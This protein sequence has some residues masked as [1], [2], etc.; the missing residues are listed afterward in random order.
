MDKKPE[1]V[2][3]VIN[4]E[5]IE[6]CATSL[7][8]STK[9]AKKVLGYLK[10]QSREKAHTLRFFWTDIIMIN[11]I[12]NQLLQTIDTATLKRMIKPVSSLEE[13]LLEYR[14]DHKK[15]VDRLRDTIIAANDN[16]LPLDY[17]RELEKY[18]KTNEVDTSE[19]DENKIEAI[20]A[21]DS[22]ITVPNLDIEAEVIFS[23]NDIP[24]NKSE[25]VPNESHT[26]DSLNANSSISKNNAKT[27][28]PTPPQYKQI[29]DD[30]E[31]VIDFSDFNNRQNNSEEKNKTNHQTNNQDDL[32]KNISSFT[33]SG[34]I[35][36]NSLFN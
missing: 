17:S 8:I 5:P 35:D 7:A 36:I 30:D 28:T 24:K 6:V 19:E 12:T 32:Q 22:D 2:I 11:I 26:N 14:E 21:T 25:T 31:T 10:R 16:D 9:K 33:Q 3:L 18:F 34:E 27:N 4:G 20:E 15:K 29:I 1:K 23:E 13:D